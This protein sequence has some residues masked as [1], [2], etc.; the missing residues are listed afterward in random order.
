VKK[1]KMKKNLLKL[2]GQREKWKGHDR[3]ALCWA[4]YIVNDNNIVDGSKPQIMK[5]IVCHV[6][7]VPFNPRTKERRGIITYY[8]KKWHNSFEKTCGCKSCYVCK[9]I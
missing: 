2:H 6:N 9:N 7:F 3:N 5:C 1:K 8:K 4:F